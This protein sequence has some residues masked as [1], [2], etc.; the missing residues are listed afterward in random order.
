M[1]IDQEIQNIQ[2]RIIGYLQFFPDL[3]EYILYRSRQ[4]WI[5][6]TLLLDFSVVIGSNLKREI[7][8]N[9]FWGRNSLYR[10]LF[11]ISIVVI[12]SFTLYSGVSQR[13]SGFQD[14]NTLGINVSQ[15]VIGANDVI[16]QYQNSQSFSF[17]TGDEFP[18][19]ILEHKVQ[20]GETL[21]SIAKLYKLN[22]ITSIQWANKIEP[23]NKKIYPGQKLLIPPMVGVLVEA[24]EGDTPKELVKDIKG[25][26]II[27]VL[28]LNKLTSEEEVLA[29]G[30]MIF[31]PNGEKALPA[32]PSR[33]TSGGGGGGGST[34]VE[35]AD[36][37][38]SVP[39]GTFVNPLGD[40]SCSG[41]TFSR[42]YSYYHTG[43]DLAKKGGCWIR[44]IGSGT[45]V[46]AR[47]CTGGLGF[48][49]IVQHDNGFQS[50]YAHGN[51]TFAVQEGQRVQAGQKVMYMGCTGRCYGTHLHMS[52]SKDIDV[53]P[54]HNRINPK[55]IVP[56]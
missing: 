10:R 42:G 31:V 7:I 15:G 30:D 25:A 3:L 52:I 4:V 47:N 28:E 5:W 53:I 6:T 12:T 38:V 16:Q 37:G 23:Y 48:C 55:G 14:S 21:D 44:S 54:Y 45:I 50:L 49:V 2:K 9:M 39:S 19:E 20:E 56:Y 18:F 11:H 24:K 27:D 8:K 40:I 41:Y 33:T 13:I 46:K 29:E 1:D 36:K 22:D 26:N 17:I 32:P 34:Y 51:G 43:V 35:L